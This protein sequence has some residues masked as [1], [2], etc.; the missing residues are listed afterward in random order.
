MTYHVHAANARKKNACDFNIQVA[1]TTCTNQKPKNTFKLYVSR[2]NTYLTEA[3]TPLT[4]LSVKEFPES[5]L[6]LKPAYT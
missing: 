4:P 3:V 1:N 5:A 6:V 2:S